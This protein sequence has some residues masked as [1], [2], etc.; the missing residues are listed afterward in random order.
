M[1]VPL[2]QVSET[3]WRWTDKVP[4]RVFGLLL[5]GTGAL[6]MFA[7][8]SSGS[9]GWIIQLLVGLVFAHTAALRASEAKAYLL[10][11]ADGTLVITRRMFY[12]PLRDRHSLEHTALL[13]FP[14]EAFDAHPDPAVCVFLCGDHR[15][16]LAVTADPKELR[17][18][19]ASLP[20]A[21]KRRVVT[22]LDV[23]EAG[24]L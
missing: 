13:V 11:E 2:K 18:Y 5:S 7:L 16:V 21:M 15:L 8:A 4:G 19:I 3:S 6:F 10:D 14:V 23:V 9:S 22:S 20:E 1:F 24:K 17:A 12:F